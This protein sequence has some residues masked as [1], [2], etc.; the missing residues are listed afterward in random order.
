MS[1]TE[2]FPVGTRVA[3]SAHYVRMTGVVVEPVQQVAGCVWVQL[4]GADGASPWFPELLT[5]I[6]ET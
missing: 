4:D 3:L 1:T 2:D 5:R 6:E